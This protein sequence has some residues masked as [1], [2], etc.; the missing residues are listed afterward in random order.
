MKSGSASFFSRRRR[1]L[2]VVTRRIS[3]GLARRHARSSPYTVSAG[4]EQTA[5]RARLKVRTMKR[6]ILIVGGAFSKKRLRP[7]INRT[8]AERLRCGRMLR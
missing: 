3:P 4:L 2:I 7:I 8:A 6:S 5:A 1:A